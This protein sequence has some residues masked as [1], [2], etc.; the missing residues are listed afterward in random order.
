MLK[1]RNIVALVATLLLAVGCVADNNGVAQSGGGKYG[2][3]Q[4]G[5]EQIPINYVATQDGED[6]LLVALSPLTDVSHFTT[7]AI[8]GVKSTLL[9]QELDVERYY[10]N[11]DYVIIYED[12]Q[13]YYAPFRRPQSGKIKMNKSGDIVSVDVDVLLFDGTPLRYKNEALPIN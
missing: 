3:L 4:F 11:D 10:C 2:M 5:E 7:K 9:D 1:F 12:P 8:V 6:M 13:C